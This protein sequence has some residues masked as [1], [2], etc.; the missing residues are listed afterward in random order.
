MAVT[1]TEKRLL[2]DGDWVETGEWID[3]RSP[4]SG[5]VVGR[6]SSGSAT[7]RSPA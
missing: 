4:Y 2:I 5:E 6:A 1:A 3:V 7:T